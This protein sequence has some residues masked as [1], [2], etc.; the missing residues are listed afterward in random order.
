MRVVLVTASLVSFAGIAS[1]AVP[2]V[3][4]YGRF[5]C[6]I[7]NGD[8]TYSPDPSQCL[9]ANLVAPG[10]DTDGTG[11]QGDGVTPV[12]PVCS[13]QLETSGYYCGIAGAACTSDSGCDN[14]LC[15]GGTCQGGFTQAC[16]GNDENCLGFLYCLSGDFT[17]TPSDTCGGV[18]AFC[19]DYTQGD[20]SFTDADN[21]AIFNQF[22]ATGYCNFNTG[23][24][25]NH[26]TTIGADC[27]SDPSFFCTQTSARQPLAC[28][29][30]TQ[31]CQPSGPVPSARA[32][33]RRAEIA[34][35]S[36]CSPGHHA[37]SVGGSLGFECMDL[38]SNLENC[39]ACGMDCTSLPGV[40]AIGCEMG[41]CTTWSCMDSHRWDAD[42][43]ACVEI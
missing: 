7:V 25:D 21:Y 11:A 41:V 13:Q 31:T 36:L 35:R 28:D 38:N 17:T 34:R 18:G 23:N 16:A 15:V 24:C 20:P 4:G 6:T 42:A 3:I 33:S 26:G 19:Q 1:A 32:R 43:E 2:T 22:C 10:A 40:N 39:G 30:I 12:D 14:G 9:N 27:S 37:C 5:P 8:G 29:A